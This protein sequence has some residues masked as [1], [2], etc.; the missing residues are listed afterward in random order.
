VF[1][2]CN[3]LNIG[4]CVSVYVSFMY[5]LF[6]LILYMWYFTNVFKYFSFLCVLSNGCSDKHVSTATI[7]PQQ[8]NGV[9]YAVYVELL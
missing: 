5:K 7:A 4:L 8:G 1:I 6:L 9:L 3:V 2:S